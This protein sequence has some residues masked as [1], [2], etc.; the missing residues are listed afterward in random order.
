MCILVV[1]DEPLIRLSTSDALRDAGFRVVEATSGCEA[2]RKFGDGREFRALITDVEMPGL[3]NGLVLAARVCAI[4]ADLAV[5][6]V[7]GHA[8]IQLGRMPI[9]SRFLSKPVDPVTLVSE[10][11]DAIVQMT[12]KHKII[13][14]GSLRL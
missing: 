2:L 6:V 11:Q 1:D 3:F 9:A 7:S 4:K 8:G 14:L 10:L 13:S 5:V 12:A